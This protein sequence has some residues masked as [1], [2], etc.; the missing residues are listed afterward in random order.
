ML[1]LN[2][3]V[4]TCTWSAYSANEGDRALSSFGLDII[5]DS[6][7]LIR[8]RGF[9]ISAVLSKPAHRM[10]VA[11]FREDTSNDRYAAQNLMAFMAH[12]MQPS[13]HEHRFIV[14]LHRISIKSETPC[15]DHAILKS[16]KLT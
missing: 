13:Q 8:A 5:E 7:P 4:N 11:S 9:H 15:C 6:G 14:L 3:V 2:E 16:I 10:T 12:I 1:H